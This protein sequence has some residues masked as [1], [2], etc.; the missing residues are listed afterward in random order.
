[1]S[2]KFWLMELFANKPLQINKDDTLHIL[3]TKITGYLM[4]AMQLITCVVYVGS[5]V[6]WVM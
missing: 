3:K 1:M 6:R 5:H 2:D 4:T